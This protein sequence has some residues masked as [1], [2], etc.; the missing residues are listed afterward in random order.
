MILRLA[1]WAVMGIALFYAAEGVGVVERGKYF[2]TLPRLEA[3][4]SDPGA[5]FGAMQ[6]GVGFVAGRMN[7]GG[8]MPSLT[9]EASSSPIHLGRLNEGVGQLKRMAGYYG[10]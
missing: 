10:G 2:P 9:R 3:S 7:E 5:W 6:W 8:A 4:A 1:N